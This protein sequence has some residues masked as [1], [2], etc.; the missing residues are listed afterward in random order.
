MPQ[1]KSPEDKQRWE[2]RYRI[3][4]LYKNLQEAQR[5]GYHYKGKNYPVPTY[6]LLELP[7]VMNG[8]LYHD[9]DVISFCDKNGSPCGKGIKVLST[10]MTL[11]M[12]EAYAKSHYEAAER[13]LLGE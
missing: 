8:F 1:S 11:K 3:L 6:A 4:P 10:H 7:N 9:G 2:S 13:I 12:A 5:N